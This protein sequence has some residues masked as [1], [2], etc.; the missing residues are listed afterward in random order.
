M[1][2]GIGYDNISTRIPEQTRVVQNRRPEERRELESTAT[3]NEQRARDRAAQNNG[4]VATP[5]ETLVQ[6]NERTIQQLQSNQERV[7]DSLDNASGLGRTAVNS[8]QSLDRKELN[9]NLSSN[10]KVDITA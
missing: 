5:T 8:Y 9:D 1:P 6:P 2:E 7:N 3:N 4:L 10:V